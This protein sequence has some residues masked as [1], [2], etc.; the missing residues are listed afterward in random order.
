M[1]NLHIDLGPGVPSYRESRKRKAEDNT[2]KETKESGQPEEKK[3][4]DA[5]AELLTSRTGGAYIPPAKLRMM[6][7]Q[8]TDKSSVAYQRMAWEALKKSING[9]INKVNVSNI[10][11]IVRELFQENIV[12]GSFHKF[13][14]F[15]QFPQNG[16]LILQRLILQFKRGF[17]RNDKNL[18]LSSTRFIAH[19][20]NQ[21]VAHEVISLEILTL[22]LENATEDSVEVAVSF[23]KELSLSALRSVL[24]E[25]QLDKR[26][27]YM[28][29][30]MFAIRKDGF[31][32]HPAVIPDLD[33]VEEDDQF[34]HLLTLEDVTTAQDQLNVFRAD[35]EYLE[36]EEK[37]KTLK[38]EILAEGSSDEGSGDESGGDS[39]SDD[40][41]DD[42]EEAEKRMRNS[43]VLLAQVLNC[44]KLTETDTTSAS[45]IFIKIL[46]LELSEYMGLPKLN[47]RLRDPEDLREHLKG[48]SKQLMQ[49]KQQQQ[50]EPAQEDASSS[51]DSSDSDSSDS[52]S[53]DSSESDSD[54]SSSGSDSSDSSSDSD[55]HKKKK[56]KQSANKGKDKKR[57]KNSKT[58]GKD[59]SGR[60]G[61][62][63]NRTDDIAVNGGGRA[64]GQR[65][66]QQEEGKKGGTEEPVTN[67]LGLAKAIASTSEPV[68]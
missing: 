1:V 16:E 46:F 60:R 40:D 4:K 12:R 8:I 26:V 52:E 54:S 5:G 21:Q 28:V 34:T 22:L 56:K 53:S 59:K 33:L 67:H 7:A 30:V 11:D 58:K 13:V 55:T 57:D 36:N 9:L 2:N 14:R 35:P 15:L 24:H 49:Q 31:K 10:I 17:R 25:G 64:Y 50:Q 61:G 38:K 23:L 3:T 48:L 44:I 19:L 63:R 51:S 47:S 20:V 66:H 27:Q 37:Y 32:D 45:R 62:D 41:D 65:S 6:Q 43:L 42:E 68:D 29:E 18:C 39:S